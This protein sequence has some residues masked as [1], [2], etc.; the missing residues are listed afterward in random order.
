MN[1]YREHFTCVEKLQQQ[2]ESGKSP[3]QLSHH[4]LW[5]LF[6]QLRDGSSLEGSIGNTARVVFAVAE[7][8]C[9]ADRAVARQRGG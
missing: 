3:R 5:K 1:L 2:W 7:H 8:P 6:Q 4:L 9:F